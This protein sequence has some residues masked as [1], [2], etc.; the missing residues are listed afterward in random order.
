[1]WNDNDVQKYLLKRGGVEMC[2]EEGERSADWT[3][4][5]LKEIELK[6]TN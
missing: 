1:M 3:R 2:V 6:E 5:V 4:R